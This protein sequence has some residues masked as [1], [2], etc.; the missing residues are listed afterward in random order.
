M[1]EDELEEMFEK[2]PNSGKFERSC[3]KAA[4]A[5]APKNAI[6]VDTARLGMR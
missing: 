4:Q 1:G 2:L 3:G 6:F 5:D